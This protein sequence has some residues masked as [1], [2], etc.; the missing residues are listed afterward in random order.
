MQNE[1]EIRKALRAL[2]DPAYQKFQ[3]GLIPNLA[4]ETV[5]GVRMPQLRRLARSLR[6]TPEAAEFLRRLPHGF[7][8]ENNLHGLLLCGSRSYPETV[9]GLDR[10]LPFVDNWA[11]CD[12]LKPRAFAPRPPELPGQLLRWLAASHPYTVRFAAG[13]LMTH[14][15]G[16]DFHPAYADA[17]A[18]LTPGEYYVDM[19][20][21]WYFATA[22][23]KRWDDAFPY[24]Q[25][26]ALDPWTRRAA[27]RKALESYR[28]APAQKDCLRALR[29]SLRDASAPQP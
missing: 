6:G 26:G 2:A 27:I 13:M 24:L 4:P 25:G 12:L 21:A 18:A 29:A 17:V 14:Y 15:L 28:I 19:M 22:L 3:S 1:N 9:A 10:F 7:Y 23:A 16:E 8:E 11:T 5:L 20:R